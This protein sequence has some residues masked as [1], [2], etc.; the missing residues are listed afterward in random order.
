M[1]YVHTIPPV[2]KLLIKEAARDQL[3]LYLSLKAARLVKFL[4]SYWLREDVD[5]DHE[6]VCLNFV[7]ITQDFAFN[8]YCQDLAKKPDFTLNIHTEICLFYIFS[9]LRVL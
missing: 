6:L 8:I 3:I 7:L 1:R 2:T 4:I 9:F 5:I